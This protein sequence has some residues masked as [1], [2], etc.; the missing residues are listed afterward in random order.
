MAQG[1]RGEVGQ[2]VVVSDGGNRVL[3]QMA[4]SP[5]RVFNVALARETRARDLS[6]S[7]R[8]RPVE[9]KED[10][11]GG[12]VWRARD[13]KNYYIARFNP[14]E[15]NFRVY[16]VV[17]GKRTQLGTVD[18]NRPEGWHTLTVR[19]VGDHIV[20]V[21]D[22]AARLDVRDATFPDAGM[23]GLWTKADARTWFDDLE[24]AA[25]DPS[26]L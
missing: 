24:L 8:L 22:G 25:A 4:S 13:A 23:I 15:D 14:L 16:K 20:C 7:V 11:G 10:Q 12:L 26:T 21:L 5:D 19:M 9:G 2:W 17:A 1:F 18:V 3:A 6:L